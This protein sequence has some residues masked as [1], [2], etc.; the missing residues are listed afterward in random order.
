MRSRFSKMLRLIGCLC[1]LG[2]CVSSCA[3]GRSAT[4][5]AQL[6][7]IDVCTS[8][9][10]VT[11]FPVVYASER[12]I[13]KKYGL[14]VRLITIDSGSRAVAA[15]I[16]NS[17]QLCQISGSSVV[18]AVIA[19]ADVAIVGALIDTDLYSLM[20]SSHI[21]SAADLKGR[22]VAVSTAGSSSETAMG[23]VLRTLGLA[24]KDVTVLSIGG[25]GERMAAL[26]AGYVDGTLVTPP[27]TIVA[28]ERGY[29]ALLDVS[30]M[31]L[32]YQHTGT[33]A[34]R[35]FLT[36]NRDI[37]RQFLKAVAESASVVRKNKQDTL[38]VL[39]SHFDLDPVEDATALEETYEMLRT[40]FLQIP[41]PSLPGIQT[42]LDES[43]TGNP[44]AKRFKPEQVVDV[45]VVREL[46][47]SGFFNT[48]QN[49][50][51]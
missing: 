22:A 20:V 42:L 7:K 37:V 24:R 5:D 30:A 26:A 8:S 16:S 46:E 48:L 34:N 50:T 32:P 28:R 4:P 14:D 19:G 31:N 43:A 17:V 18:N 45:S 47:A 2:L 23:M 1:V 11:Q 29:H 44:D 9:T 40:R 39:S 41:Y 51:R 49:E 38:A 33:V 27:E 36:T 12:G 6:T 35:R 3:T 21:H 10:N 25:Q 15:L 13:F